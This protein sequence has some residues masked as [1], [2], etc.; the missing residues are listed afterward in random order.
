VAAQTQSE[1]EVGLIREQ[2]EYMAD[3]Q[4]QDVDYMS[5]LLDWETLDAEL[6]KLSTERWQPIAIQ[7]GPWGGVNPNQVAVV[8]TR[9][10]LSLLLQEFATSIAKEVEGI[11]TNEEDAM[12]APLLVPPEDE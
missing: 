3:Q 9:Q 1:E 7:F 6:Q 4:T 12:T 8:L 5:V 2:L 11:A 10:D